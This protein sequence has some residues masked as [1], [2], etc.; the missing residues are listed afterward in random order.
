MVYPVGTRDTGSRLSSC[1]NPLGGSGRDLSS[2]LRKILGVATAL[3]SSHWWP[4]ATVPSS[5]EAKGP[6]CA[7]GQEAA[8]IV[9]VVGYSLA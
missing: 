8:D 2:L 1:F 7:V 6:S 5:K 9:Y 4:G 3:F